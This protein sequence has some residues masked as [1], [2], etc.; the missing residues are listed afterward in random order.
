MRRAIA[1]A[2][3][4]PIQIGRKRV[5]SR[6]RRMTIG[7]FDEGSSISPFTSIWTVSSTGPV[8]S[9]S[10]MRL[11]WAP[12]GGR[13]RLCSDLWLFERP[14]VRAANRRLCDHGFDSAGGE[15]VRKGGFDFDEGR[16]T[17]RLR[18]GAG[19]EMDDPMAGRAADLR[20]RLLAPTGDEHVEAPADELL[21]QLAL[22]SVLDGEDLLKPR[23]RDRRSHLAVEARSRG[24]GALGIAE[25]EHDGKTDLFEEVERRLE[26]LVA[27]ARK[28]DDQVGREREVGPRG[29]QLADQIEVLGARVATAHATEHRIAPALNGQVQVGADVRKTPDPFDHPRRK[30]A[31]VRGHEAQP[32]DAFGRGDRGQQV[33]EVRLAL[34]VAPM[35]DGLAE[36]LDLPKA[37]LHQVTDLG[38]DDIHCPAALRPAGLGHDAKG[39]ALVAPFDDRHHPLVF[40]LARDR[41]EVVHPFVRESGRDRTLA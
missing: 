36:K 34:R 17:E 41:V 18:R 16:A 12:P 1:W 7:T 25:R 39:A 38:Q 10:L 8:P 3:A 6:S 11:L 22:D 30:I 9:A 15:A 37:V 5:F 40:A 32:L 14:E 23:A 29:A 31:R 19:S 21:V 20:S 24:P 13:S 28:A 35:V 2:S 4:M 33:G 27:F 26:V